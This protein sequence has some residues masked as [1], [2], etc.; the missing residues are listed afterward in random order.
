MLGLTCRT[1][2]SIH[3]A[4]YHYP[5]PL[6]VWTAMPLPTAQVCVRWAFFF[7]FQL[8]LSCE[9]G[10]VMGT[11]LSLGLKFN[12]LGQCTF[13]FASHGLLPSPSLY[14]LNIN[15]SCHGYG[16]DGHATQ[17]ERQQQYVM[18]RVG[19]LVNRWTEFGA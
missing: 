14:Q 8:H 12:T 4:T 11:A 7:R 3:R 6:Q 1:F 13:R 9:P 10:R 15:F 2:Y 18:R 16:W 19:S 17:I 5:V